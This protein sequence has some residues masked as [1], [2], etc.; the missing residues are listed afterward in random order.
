MLSAA[1][2]SEVEDAHKQG[3]VAHC[4]D[5][6]PLSFVCPAP[7]EKLP[8]GAAEEAGREQGEAAA[9][10]KAAGLSVMKKRNFISFP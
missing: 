7:G 9:S 8:R 1:R 6:R 5:L 4:W 3:T 2:G 10:P